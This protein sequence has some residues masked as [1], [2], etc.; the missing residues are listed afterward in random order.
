MKMEARNTTCVAKAEVIKPLDGTWEE[1]GVHMRDLTRV[2]FRMMNTAIEAAHLAEAQGEPI[3]TPIYNAVKSFLQQDREWNAKSIDTNAKRKKLLPRQIVARD[4]RSKLEVPSLIYAVAAR[5]AEQAWGTYKAEKFDGTRAIPSFEDH[6]SFSVRCDAWR[7]EKDG[8]GYVLQVKLHGGTAPWTRF[9]IGPDGGSAF[10]HFRRLALSDKAEK[11]SERNDLSPEEKEERKALRKRKSELSPAE[12]ERL[13]ALRP[14]ISIPLNDAIKTGDLQLRWVERRN[15]SGEGKRGMWMAFATYT[16]ELKP[17]S[18]DESRVMA[19]HRGMHSL[20][21]WA[22]SDGVTGILVP[23]DNILEHKRRY[24]AIRVGYRRCRKARGAGGIGHGSARTHR[25]YKKLDD[26]EAR[27]VL[28]QCQQWAARAIQ[29][30]KTNGCGLILIEDYSSIKNENPRFLP[31]WPWEKLKTCIEHAAHI[32]GITVRFVPSTYIS[33]TCP[34]CR[35][36]SPENRRWSGKASAAMATARVDG[37]RGKLVKNEVGVERGKDLSGRGDMF[38]CVSCDL[39]RNIDV[40][41]AFNMLISGGF[42]DEAFRKFE[43][44]LEKFCRTLKE[45]EEKLEE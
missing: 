43:K 7:V 16:R 38:H 33:Q 27:F 30:A 28:T 32:E 5:R 17:V 24:Q 42:S 3:S 1:A 4:R 8:R 31:S 15:K 45:E 22:T 34:R 11:L 25:E 19:I 14:E 44:A 40:I 39:H 41:A 12:E 23:G 26:T 6:T 29:V 35:H 13:Y 10:E 20:L 9:V 21:T 2:W 37:V 36:V 18:M